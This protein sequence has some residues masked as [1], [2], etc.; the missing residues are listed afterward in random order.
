MEMDNLLLILIIR[1]ITQKLDANNS[2]VRLL[3]YEVGF[4]MS[5]IL[6]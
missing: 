5:I 2:I 1:K 4:W 3:I 6:V